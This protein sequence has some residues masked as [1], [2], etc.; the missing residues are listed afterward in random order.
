[1]LSIV[2]WKCSASDRSQLRY[3]D[4]RAA[5][6]SVYELLKI[7]NDIELPGERSVSPFIPAQTSYQNLPLEQFRTFAEDAHSLQTLSA[8][9][10]S[11]AISA[12]LVSL[13]PRLFSF[14]CPIPSLRKSF[15]TRIV[16]VRVT[17]APHLFQEALIRH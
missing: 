16:R 13:H 5:L 3:L 6:E 14:P 9:K 11:R 2:L 7:W 10:Y 15:G 17:F 12:T 1:M 4:D 8:S